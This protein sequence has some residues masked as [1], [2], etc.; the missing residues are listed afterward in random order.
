MTAKNPHAAAIHL[1]IQDHMTVDPKTEPLGWQMKGARELT[2]HVEGLERALSTAEAGLREVA[3]MK[4]TSPYSGNV[5]WWVDCRDR[6]RKSM[7]GRKSPEEQR[8]GWC[9]RC[10]AADAL[11]HLPE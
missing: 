8:R 7:G 6:E 10:V 5:R 1:W 3:E 2:R 11:E 4:C 9:P